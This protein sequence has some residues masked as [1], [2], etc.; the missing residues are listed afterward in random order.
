MNVSTWDKKAASYFLVRVCQKK[1]HLV[2]S[3]GSNFNQSH[4]DMLKATCVTKW[5]DRRRHPT[6]PLNTGHMGS[7]P[8][9]DQCWSIK[10]SFQES[11]PMWTNKDQC[12]S[13]PILNTYASEPVL[14]CID[15]HWSLLLSQIDLYWL[16]LIGNDLYWA[17]FWINSWKLIFIYR[18]WG[19]IRHVLLIAPPAYGIYLYKWIFSLVFL[20]TT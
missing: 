10:I 20:W 15:W 2:P 16:L 13:L 14:I 19:L 3:S 7:I 1:C 8:N 5:Q 4:Q 18:H 11:I 6:R 17:R 9:D 12:R